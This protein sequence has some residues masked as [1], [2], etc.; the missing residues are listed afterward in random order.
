MNVSRRRFSR[1]VIYL[2]LL[3]LLS[4]HMLLAEEKDTV[5]RPEIYAPFIT[6]ALTI[7]GNPD[8]WTAI[9]ALGEG[10]EYYKGD[11]KQGTSAENLGTTIRKQVDDRD[12]LDCKTWVC[13]DGTYLY[14]LAEVID[15]DWQPFDSENRVNM[16]Y[17]EDMLR[18]MIDSNNSRTANIEEC[19]ENHPGYE[20]F[21]F[22]TDGNIY[23]DW[24]DF[25]T[26]GLAKR[27]P[28]KGSAPDGIY[29]KAECMVVSLPVKNK[30]LYCYEERIKM[31]GW[32]GRNM[33]K[34]YP[35]MSY[36]FN[37]EACDADDGEYLQGYILWSSDGTTSSWKHQNLWGTIH[38][39]PLPY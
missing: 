10:V 2:Y 5:K 36:G 30:H 15:D 26:S 16:C 4:A 6:T 35:G 29:W 9:K 39:A 13:H 28:P 25:N 23:G 24:S 21:G 22:S 17:Q 34:L 27:H 38:L 1:I 31:E 7:D 11:G 12:D 3:S 18:I 32:P 33:E 14:V 20:G 19:I 37:L 8:D